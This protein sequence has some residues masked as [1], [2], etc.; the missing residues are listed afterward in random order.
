MTAVDIQFDQGIPRTVWLFGSDE[1]EQ[2][3]RER[4]RVLAE[5]KAAGYPAKVV[6]I[7]P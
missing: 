2:L 6:V 5:R 1:L 7:V 3:R 4:D